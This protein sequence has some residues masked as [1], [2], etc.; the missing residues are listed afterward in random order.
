MLMNGFRDWFGD[1]AF[2]RRHSADVDIGFIN[3]LRM[4]TGGFVSE[5]YVLHSFD[6]NDRCDYVN[7]LVR[8]KKACRFNGYYSI[9]LYD[10]LY[11]TR[12]LE[13]FSE[14]VAFIFGLI[15]GGRFLRVGYCGSDIVEAVVE[16]CEDVGRV[17][18]KPIVG[19]RGDGVHVVCLE[20]GRW[21]L[22]GRSV[23][24]EELV[25][26]FGRLDDYLVTEFVV[27]GNYASEIYPSSSNTIRILTL[28]DDESGEPFV[29][30]AVHR[31]GTDKSAPVDNWTL[32][33]VSCKV[34]LDTGR[35]GRAVSYP[36]RGEMSFYEEHPESGSRIEGVEVPGWD[37]VKSRII[38]MAQSMPFVPYIGW[39]VI[40][41]ESGFKVIEG[42]NCPGINLL[43]VH[44]PL[45]RDGRIRRFYENRLAAL[46]ATN[47]EKDSY[48]LPV[49]I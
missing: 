35:L 44:G 18:I 49:R 29:A 28:W 21:V 31:F 37:R 17:V 3:K 39:D 27:Q 40:V 20:N 47:G 7:D 41:T 48:K 38:E 6:E 16:V 19:T 15:R 5:A 45:L 46:A 11:F 33:G 9:V 13:E 25:C 24:R 22:D 14:N 32:G 36:V 23:S 10:K 30:R 42:N 43:Q 8:L 12:M 4:W 1:I 2:L 26:F 34:D